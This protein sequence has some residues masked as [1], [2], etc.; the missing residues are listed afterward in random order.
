IAA[1][2][3]RALGGGLE[4][5]EACWLRVAAGDAW[6]G[7]PEVRIGAVAGFGGTTRLARLI[8]KGRAAEMLL[9]GRLV[10]AREALATGLVNRVVPAGEAVP[11]ATALARDI[12]ARPATAV[13][14][15]WEAMHRGLDMAID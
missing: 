6:L 11:A 9:T 3:G 13:R 12:A 8:G 1:I 10:D 15:N 5:A 2:E 14:L 7:H 4:I